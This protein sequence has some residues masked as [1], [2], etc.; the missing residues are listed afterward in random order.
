MGGED[1]ATA[2]RPCNTGTRSGVGRESR[3]EMGLQSTQQTPPRPTWLAFLEPSLRQATPPCQA[4]TGPQTSVTNVEANGLEWD[5]GRRPHGT[6]GSWPSSR[7]RSRAGDT[8]PHGGA[9]GM[10]V[11]AR[12][13]AS[14]R[15]EAAGGGGGQA[16]GHSDRRATDHSPLGGCTPFPARGHPPP[17]TRG[18][19]STM[20]TQQ[21]V[22]SAGP[23]GG[24]GGGV[25]AQSPRD[26]GPTERGC[27]K[28]N[29]GQDGEGARSAG[30]GEPS[31]CGVGRCA[32][33]PGCG[34]PA[35]PAEPC[36]TAAVRCRR[37]QVRK[38]APEFPFLFREE[39]KILDSKGPEPRP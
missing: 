28:V 1:A 22:L 13:A 2:E 30:E 8:R 34:D 23:Q 7:T 38:P 36:H 10:Q 11:T 9:A 25:A 5:C 39:G 24:G 33:D 21:P 18:A 3:P 29:S 12:R 4:R 15:P 6:P 26:R 14:P 37:V 35:S 27:A 16:T 31:S 32:R 19:T 17:A 20:Q